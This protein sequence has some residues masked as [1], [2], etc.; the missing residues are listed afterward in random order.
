VDELALGQGFLCPV[1]IIPPVFYT[2]LHLNT[3]V[4]RRADERSLGTI[5]QR[6]ALSD[7]GDNWTEK[8]LL[9]R[10]NL[11]KSSG[12]LMLQQV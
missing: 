9:I 11:L 8:Y 4:V 3:N 6:N 5:K 12:Y 7:I 1:T 2:D 10:I